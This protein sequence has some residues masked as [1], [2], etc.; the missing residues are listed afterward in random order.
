MD[1]NQARE[2]ATRSDHAERI[3]KDPII[4]DAFTAIRENIFKKIA[5]S[6]Y[7]QADQREDLYRMLRAI[8]S[9]EGQFKRYINDGKIARNRL[10][11]ILRK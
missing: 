4:N 11:E 10:K 8:E 5:E 1:E 3:L 7:T 6:D 9:F 2:I